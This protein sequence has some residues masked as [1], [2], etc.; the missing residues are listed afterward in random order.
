M[1]VFIGC[2]SSYYFNNLTLKFGGDY[3]NLVDVGYG[4][5]KLFKRRGDYRHRLIGMPI[6][7]GSV[8][9]MCGGC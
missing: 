4:S 7:C 2:L 6:S 9:V 1:L 3:L 5:Y 8:C